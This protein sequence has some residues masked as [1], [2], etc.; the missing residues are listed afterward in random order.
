VFPQNS[1]PQDQFIWKIVEQ[2]GAVCCAVVDSTV[3]HVV[4]LDPGTEKALWAGSNKKFLVHPQWIEAANF[5]W[6]RHPEEEFPVPPLNRKGKERENAV[7]NHHKK[8]L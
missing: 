3:T 6:C 4:A 5:R 7:A 2:L 8:T 1:R